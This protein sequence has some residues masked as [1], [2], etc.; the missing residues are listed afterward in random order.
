MRSSPDRPNRFFL[1]IRATL[2][3]GGF[4]LG[5]VQLRAEDIPAE[6][7]EFFETKVRPVLVENCYE[8]HSVEAGKQKG[9]L[10][11]D[12]RWGWETGGDSGAALVPGDPDLSLLID[13]V[14]RTEIIVDGMPPKSKLPEAQIRDLEQW[15]R[16]GAPDPR[17]KVRPGEAS[18]FEAFDLPAR[19]QA[20][21]S[22]RPVQ[23]PTPP[24]VQDPD[25]P[26]SDIDRFILARIEAAGLQPARAAAPRTWL[27]RVTFDL[28]GLPPSPEQ[29]GAFLAGQSPEAVVEEL[30]DSPHFGEKWARHWMDLVRYAETYGHE[31]DYAIEHAYQYRDYLIRALNAD[32][33]YDQLV[34]EHIAGD[35]LPEPRTHPG[36]GFNESIIGTGFWY[37]HDATHAPTDVLQDEADHQ[38]NQL[39]VFGKTFQGLTIACARCHD[40]KF[41]AISTQDYYALTGYLQGSCRTEVPLDP[42]GT[43]AQTAARLQSL[44][45]QATA[46]LT[47]IP[48]DAETRAR[49]GPLFLATVDWVRAGADPAAV[50]DRADALDL[51]PDRLAAWC[52]LLDAGDDTTNEFWAGWVLNPEGA[53]EKRRDLQGLHDRQRRFEEDST[54]FADFNDGL[55][56]GWV[57]TGQG[58]QGT[59]PSA[60]LSFH[61]AGDI[62]AAPGLVDSG[63]FGRNQVGTL[64]SPTFTIPA[65]KIHVRTRAKNVLM[66]VVP[67]NYHMAI[68][69]GLLFKGTFRQGKDTD[70]GENCRWITFEQDLRKY[71]GQN[72]YLEFVDSSGGFVAIDD[73]RFAEGIDAPA[74]SDPMLAR[75]LL[76]D[77]AVATAEGMARALDRVW[78]DVFASLRRGAGTAED[79]AVV[80]RLGA[81][82]LL[83]AGDL[84]PALATVHDE[85]RAFAEGVSIPCFA[86]AM[87]QGTPESARVNVR[88]NPGNLGDLVP[89]RYLEALGGIEGNRL[90]LARQI[91]DPANPLTTRVIVNRLWHHL[92]G[93]GLVPTPDD[94]GPQGRPPSHPELL[95][96]LATDFTSNGW[97]VK[98]ALRQIVLSQTYRQTALAHPDLDPDRIARV[99]PQNTLLHR[100]PIR[101]LQAE[102]I[103]DA[104]LA[105]SGRLDRRLY[106]PSIV[107][108]RTPYMT[109]RGARDSGPLDGAGRRSIYLS[110]YRNFLNPFLL[111]FDMPGPFGSKGRR[112]Q[113]NVPAQA[114]TLMNDPFVVQQ[115]KIWAERSL[116]DPN[117]TLPQRV[118]AMVETATGQT[119]TDPQ[120]AALE[121]FLAQQ[122]DEYGALDERA[123]ADLAHALFNAKDFIYLR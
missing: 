57:V 98:H 28:T 101:R 114:L 47:R 9:G 32:V 45:D 85:G 111:T 18:T 27:R 89:N 115:A 102:A 10:V 30:L 103:R 92:F 34:R 87:T 4:A 105:V 68:H 95:D 62:L 14:R 123:W 42:G 88:G 43:L 121:Q 71:V 15:V 16:Y 49:P 2:V 37:F 39:D 58:F 70:T 5:G 33:P 66:R 19:V 107:T 24:A 122:A 11:L 99:D 35:L 38:A 116:A 12:S 110:I 75:L 26:A 20:H 29:I 46:L 108:H 117:Q 41:D 17:S 7:L 72:A 25:W 22:W 79:A 51:D 83:S 52:R 82:G 97:S 60:G 113:S 119:V 6:H 36:E 59:G 109:G 69:N 74:P 118:G 67:G 63:L 40:H 81:L 90:D 96:W 53:L 84:H 80:N 56:E 91:V 73:I 23:R 65:G 120:L 93:R 78:T 94:F 3:V 55:P 86:L 64:R 61:S 31:F 100:M 54:L 76:G 8:C 106:G 21:W 1:V 112:S 104:I 48:H 44:R 13:A 77:E 50:A